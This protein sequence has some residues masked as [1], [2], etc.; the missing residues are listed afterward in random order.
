MFLVDSHCH[1]DLLKLEAN[2]NINQ[3]LIR[4]KQQGVQ[5]ILNVCVKISEFNKI[6]STALPYSFI[7]ISAGLHPNEV[8]EDVDFDTLISLASHQ[9]VVAI[10]ETGLDY[11]RSSGDLTWQQERF[12]MHITVAKELMKPLIVHTR[13]AK[14]DTIHILHEMKA[15]DCGGVMHCFTEDWATAKKALDLGFYLSFSGII[16]FKNAHDLQEVVKKA[17]LDRIL[18]ETDAPYLAP[19]PYRGKQN[20][21]AYVLHTAEYIASLYQLPLE[22]IADHTTRNFFA[23]FKGAKQSYV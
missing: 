6:L 21:P 3:V 10:G 20:E 12:R 5:H 16:T 23:L 18:I 13:A 9:K 4:A 17:P 14:E 2:D 11:F 7:D 8:E 19:N 15:N 1:L 22:Q